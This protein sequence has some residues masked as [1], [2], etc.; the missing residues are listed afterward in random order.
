VPT[1]ISSIQ[2]KQ[3]PRICRK[4][5]HAGRQRELRRRWAGREW[6]PPKQWAHGFL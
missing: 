6:R 4:R 3:R 5:L 1:E 2:L